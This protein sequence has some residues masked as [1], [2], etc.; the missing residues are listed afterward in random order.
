[1]PQTKPEWALG[2]YVLWAILQ[3]DFKILSK[4]FF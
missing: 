3:D 1:M 2:P 4:M